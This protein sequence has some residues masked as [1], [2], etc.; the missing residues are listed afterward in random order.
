MT[1]I[2]RTFVLILT[3][4]QVAYSHQGQ[5][6]LLSHW[7][8]TDVLILVGLLTVVVMSFRKHRSGK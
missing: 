1:F 4:N 7:H 8:L 5:G 3:L 2:F 6:V